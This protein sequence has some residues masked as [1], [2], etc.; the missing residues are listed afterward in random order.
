MMDNNTQLQPVSQHYDNPINELSL[1]DYF[2]F[3]RIHLKKINMLTLFGLGFATYNTYTIPP[4]Y[5]AT[6]TVMVR[7]KP[8]ANMVMDFGGKRA[9]N[10]MENEIQLINSR[11]LAKE[12]VQE[13]WNSSRRNNLHVF[14]TRVF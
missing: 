12:V 14:G 8:G 1:R 10:R 7:E 4:Q 3:L 5:W 6:A 9:I 13:L 2:I 11:A